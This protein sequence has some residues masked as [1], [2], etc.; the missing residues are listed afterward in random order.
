MRW[1]RVFV[2]ASFLHSF[3]WGIYYAFTRYY[4]VGNLGGYSLL[5]LLV[6]AEWG[7]PVFSVLFGALA[8]RYGRRVFIG[9][10]AS[11]ALSFL[12]A[13]FVADPLLYVAV[14]SY[15]SFA[16][17]MSWPC[18]LAPV[19][20]GGRG[21]GRRYGVFSL[22]G[23]VGWCVGSVVEG[24]LYISLQGY[25]LVVAGLC[26]LLAYVLYFVAFPREADHGGEGVNLVEFVEAAV[27]LLPI[28][29]SVA[30]SIFG[31]E[32]AYNVIAVKLREEI[33]ALAASLGFD[34]S[35]VPV[36][37]G[38]MYGGLPAVLAVPARVAA[39]V[40]ADKVEPVV[41][42][43]CVEAVYSVY[44]L[45]LQAMSGLPVILLWQLPLYPFYDIAT[46]TAVARHSPER[47]RAYATSV[48]VTAKSIGGF[49]VA[50]VGSGADVIGPDIIVYIACTALAASSAVSAL[51]AIS[52]KR[53]GTIYTA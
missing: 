35:V 43:A 47:L 44:M 25:V 21:A 10:G 7:L 46:Y 48:V 6:G 26:Y 45:G 51:Y 32:L 3:A 37:Y 15:A 41:M 34:K 16:W 33:K 36:L 13:P 5:L 8:E 1:F 20:G 14:L 4:I 53:R 17:G 30:L 49:A 9:L 52:L 31:M 12:V 50:L 40:I 23:T 29:V 19:L 38:I 18:V 24:V 39:G 2:V 28:F 11:G 22:S 27:A 42:L